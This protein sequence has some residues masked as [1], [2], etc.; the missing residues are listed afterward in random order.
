MDAF[1]TYF[2]ASIAEVH[3]IPGSLQGQIDKLEAL[4]ER[5][6]PYMN[7]VNFNFLYNSVG[8]PYCCC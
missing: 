6:K 4:K 1:T 3:G 2:V 5:Y 8:H 7:R